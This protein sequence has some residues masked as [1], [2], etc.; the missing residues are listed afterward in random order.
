[1]DANVTAGRAAE[2]GMAW[3]ELRAT[4]ALA[5][6]LA[7][8]NLSQHAMALTD[9]VILG[10]LSTEALAAA[11]LAAQLYWAVMA[12]P[13]GAG[14]AAAAILAQQRGAGGRGWM[15]QMR[16]GVRAGFAACL[17]FLAPAALLLWFAEPVL[18]ALGQQPVLAALAQEYLRAMLWSLI[19]FSGFLVLRGFLAAMERPGPALWM[20]LAAI[21]VNGALCWVLVFPAGLGIFGAGLATLIANLAMLAGL[22]VLIARDRRLRRFRLLGRFWRVDLAML[23]EVFRIGLPICGSMLLEIGVFSAAALA[24]GVFGAAAVAAHA[25][26][27]QTAGLTFM[28]PLGIGQAATARVGFFAGAGDA[29]GARRAGWA[30][31]G[32]AAGFMAAMALLLILLARPIADGFIGA[33]DA[34]AAAARALAVTLVTIAGVFQFADGIQVAA[35]GALRGIKDTRVP[36]LAGLLGYWVL[37][38]PIGLGLSHGIGF[39]PVGL[40]V[41]LAAGLA[42]VAALLLWRWAILSRRPLADAALAEA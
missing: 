28:V 6:P 2:R 5:W 21:G 37:G 22:L 14:F 15:R 27:L 26:A 17:G 18:L 23:R 12:G 1:M 13:L 3:A 8:T 42:V 33:V 9:A 34:E 31:V 36:L 38:M 32:L 24:M 19:P 7:L 11:T 39:G 40:W 41:G 25:V 30:A 35:A 4:L 20:A 10:R 29:A 16:R